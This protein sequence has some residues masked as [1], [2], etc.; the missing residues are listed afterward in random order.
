MN[1]LVGMIPIPNKGQKPKPTQFK[2][3]QKRGKTGSQKMV[4]PY[5]YLSL[6]FHA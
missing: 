3:S 1:E 6:R 2:L 5:F 4:S